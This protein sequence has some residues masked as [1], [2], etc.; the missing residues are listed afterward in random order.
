MLCRYEALSKSVKIVLVGKYTELSDAYASVVK[1]LRHAC[2]QCN[3]KLELLYVE[4]GDLEKTTEKT[5]PERYHQAWGRLCT[6]NGILVPGGFGTRGLEGKIAAIE[7]ARTKKV[8]F[9]GICLGFQMAVIEHARN[10]MKWEGAH[11]TEA[12]PE[13]PYPVI[14]D[15]PEISQTVMGGTQRLGKRRTVFNRDCVTK[16]MYGD[17][18]GVD[19]RHRHR[20]VGSMCSMNCTNG[21]FSIFHVDSYISQSTHP[22]QV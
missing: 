8:P 3:R 18:D 19:E 5:H 12:V 15:M 10:V 1:A 6:G 2:V 22:Q 9:L 14:I 7:W 11:T 16:T 21:V 4:A 17:V 13:T 20:Y